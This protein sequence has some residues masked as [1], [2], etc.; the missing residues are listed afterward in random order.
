M[1][2]LYSTPFRKDP[3][4][5]HTIVTFSPLR[6]LAIAI[7]LKRMKTLINSRFLDVATFFGIL[8]GLTLLVVSYFQPE[9]RV[10]A[11]PALMML[12]PSLVYGMR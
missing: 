3:P 5:R 6:R 9:S 12:F 7:E 2:R 8:S 11:I 4:H 10:L 1:N